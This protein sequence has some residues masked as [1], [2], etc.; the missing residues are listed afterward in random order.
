[1]KNEAGQRRQGPRQVSK[2]SDALGAQEQQGWEATVT[3]LPAPEAAAPGQAALPHPPHQEDAGVKGN[4]DPAARL[5]HRQGGKEEEEANV[6][7]TMLAL[8]GKLDGI[9]FAPAVMTLAYC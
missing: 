4:T 8:A 3:D 7:D 5:P 1:M 2:S 9:R 6:A